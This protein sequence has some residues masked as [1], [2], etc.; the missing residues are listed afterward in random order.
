M[1]VSRLILKN[2]RNFRN[3][4]VNLRERQFLVGPNASGKSNLTKAMAC[5]KGIVQ[6][7]AGYKPS[8]EIPV[9]PFL[10]DKKTKKKPSTFEVTF[11][12]DG[13]K[14]QYGFSATSK[15]ICREWLLAWPVGREQTWFERDCNEPEPYIGPSLRGQNKS[16]WSK[17]KNNSLFLSKSSNIILHKA[18]VLIISSRFIGSVPYN[19]VPLTGIKTSLKVLIFF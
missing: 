18:I 14:Y 17:V 16:I 1:I 4:D 19:F 3:V 7:S 8:A 2:W 9:T 13:I 5:M 6:N 12:I 10:F 11:F 15:K